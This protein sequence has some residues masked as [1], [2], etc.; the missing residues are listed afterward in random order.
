M[1]FYLFTFSSASSKCV[2]SATGYSFS[3]S[4]LGFGKSK[5]HALLK[6]VK[7]IILKR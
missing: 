5:N 1:R 7:Y 2:R 6:A 4:A 3:F